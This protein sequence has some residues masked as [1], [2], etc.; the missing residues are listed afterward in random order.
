MKSEDWC[1]LN[2]WN[3]DFSK[4]TSQSHTATKIVQAEVSNS[5]TRY[6][7]DGHKLSQASIH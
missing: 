3:D 2:E 1:S 7:D 5:Q 4:F 6:T